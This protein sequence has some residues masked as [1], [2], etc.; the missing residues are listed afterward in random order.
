MNDIELGTKGKIGMGA[1]CVACCAVPMLV[2]TGALSAAVAVGAGVAL[3]A[4]TLVVAV[5]FLATSGR[6]DAVPDRARW[7]LGAVGAVVAA[8][9]LWWAD[10]DGTARRAVLSAAVAVLA[11][12][13]LLALGAAGHRRSADA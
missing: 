4:V 1:A 9:G 6:L 12:A 2:V 10:G 13:G 8:G 3:G 7:A 11:T 5:A